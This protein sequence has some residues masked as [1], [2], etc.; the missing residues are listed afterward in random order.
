PPEHNPAEHPVEDRVDCRPSVYKGGDLHPSGVG[1]EVV[2]AG[3]VEG[4]RRRRS[5]LALV[6]QVGEEHLGVVFSELP[7]PVGVEVSEPRGHYSALF[8]TSAVRRCTSATRAARITRS[9]M[10]SI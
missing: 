3:A 7:D 8:S 9:L 5:L 4:N 10:P 6:E 1:L 2:E